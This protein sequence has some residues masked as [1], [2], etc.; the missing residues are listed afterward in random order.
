M[1]MKGEEKG[2]RNGSGHSKK[3][4]FQSGSGNNELTTT[5]E[6]FCEGNGRGKERRKGSGR[7]GEQGERKK[8]RSS[9]VLAAGSQ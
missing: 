6:S 8:R 4:F 7:S 1:M 3:G 2:R 9:V 5:F